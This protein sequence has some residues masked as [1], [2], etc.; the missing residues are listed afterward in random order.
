MDVRGAHR[1]TE[2]S[3][4]EFFQE[5]WQY[6]TGEHVT[7]IGPTG[8][9]KTYITAQ[10]LRYSATPERP[11]IVL[12]VKPRDET[13][14]TWAKALKYPIVREWPP[15]LTKRITNNKPSGWI[16]WPKHE[17]DPEIDDPHLYVEF[18]KAILDSYKR[19]NR[20]ILA[21]EVF[22][23]ATELG[24]KRELKT[25]WSRGRSMGLGVWAGTQRPREIP[26]HAYDQ[27]HHLFLAH[28]PDE[29][30]RERFDEIGGVD[31]RIVKDIVLRLG[32]KEF[33][34]IRRD[35]HRMCLITK[36]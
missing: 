6:R 14:D 11:A 13:L 1:L 24:M 34:Y 18:R 7:L 19:G 9:G 25:I 30:M 21:D 4:E 22:A 10:L 12:G 16:L 36:E 29:G 17:F 8:S 23:L 32:D 31:P 3:R 15:T 26:L 20:I 2:F 28:T 27:A 33:L 5:R 35:G